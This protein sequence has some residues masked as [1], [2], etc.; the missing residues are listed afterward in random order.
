MRISK[1]ALK[2]LAMLHSL[3][4]ER[5]NQMSLASDNQLT[6]PD[7]YDRQVARWYV[8]HEAVERAEAILGRKS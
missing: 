7:V 4:H 5:H 2:I 8:V 1:D 6:S 3:E